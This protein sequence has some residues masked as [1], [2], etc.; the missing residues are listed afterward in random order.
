MRVTAATELLDALVRDPPAAL[1]L[2]AMR[3]PEV[4]AMAAC[5]QPANHHSEGDVLTHSRLALTAL[6]DLDAQ[7]DRHA[8][9]QL[10]AAGCWPLDLPAPTP[11]TTLAVALHDVG[12]P[13]TITG[14]AG[15][16]TYHGH[17]AVGARIAAR[18]VERLGLVDAAARAGTPLD[19]PLLEWLVSQHLFWLTA[20]IERVGDRAVGRRFVDDPGRG[21]A[22]RVVTWCDTLGSRGPDGRAHVELAVAAEQRIAAV[23]RRAAVPGPAPAL[24]GEEIMA[25]LDLGPGPR[26]GAV[27]AWLGHHGLSG[28]AARCAVTAA[29]DE[30]RA[31]ELAELRA[32]IPAPR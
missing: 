26:V 3:A 24:R 2:L 1:D 21:D 31:G 7:L 11:T 32:G 13:R 12:K 28:A 22:L 30:L 19:L 14:D 15:A 10:R 17:D 23:R 4:A 6:A 29:R 18:L 25:A 8:G 9:P 27:L 5:P 16:W 20:G